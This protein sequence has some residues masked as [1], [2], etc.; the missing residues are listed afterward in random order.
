MSLKLA[1]VLGPLISSEKL[2]GLKGVKCGDDFVSISDLYKD[3]IND[4]LR[5]NKLVCLTPN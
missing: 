5:L 2:I 4:S 1:L 3:K